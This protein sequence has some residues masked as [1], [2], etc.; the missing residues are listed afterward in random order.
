MKRRS[1][2]TGTMQLAALG[3]SGAHRIALGQQAIGSRVLRF[4]TTPVFL[5]DQA[6]FLTRWAGYLS[7]AVG[8][9]VEFNSRR[10]YRDIMGMLRNDE[11]DLA[12]ICGFPW[13]VH[14]SQLRGLCIP[15]YHNEPWYQSYLIVSASD[16]QTASPKDL[17]GKTF[18]YSDP[19]SNSGYLVPRTTLLKAGID[20]DRYFAR[21]F[22]TWGHRNVVSAVASG[23]ADAGAV[24]GYVWETLK[25]VAPD[26]VA[27]TRVVWRSESYGFPPLA[28]RASLDSETELRLRNAF[29]N[30]HRDKD[31]R[32]LL[33]ELNLTGFAAFRPEV[34]DGI[35][36][37]TAIVNGRKP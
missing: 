20:P 7:G 34:F 36:R 5:D 25:Q 33:V 37:L 13:V 26:L 32:R 15:L 30:M 18:A 11:L 23:L 2:L 28:V 1:F 9:K 16:T 29:L 35:A 12:W 19:D 10:S 14:Q 31:G 3:L 4:G 27:K 17:R 8:T 22:F 21:S 24:D 6:G